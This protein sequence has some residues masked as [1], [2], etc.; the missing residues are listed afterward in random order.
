M[1]AFDKDTD[2]AGIIE[3]G[4]SVRYRVLRNVVASAGY[5]FWYLLGVATV[6][7]QA[8]Y[9]ITPA[10]GNRVSAADEVFFHGAT[11]GLEVSF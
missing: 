8:I 6:P 9:S 11:A 2:I 4:S 1:N 5:E 7:R 10:T 3:T